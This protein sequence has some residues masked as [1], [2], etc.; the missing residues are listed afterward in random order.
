M[1]WYGVYTHALSQ[2]PDLHWI[3]FTS[4]GQMVSVNNN[5]KNNKNKNNSY[6]VHYKNWNWGPQPHPTDVFITLSG[7]YSQILVK[8]RQANPL[9]NILIF[10]IYGLVIW[11][12]LLLRLPWYPANLHLLILIQQPILYYTYIS[13]SGNSSLKLV[14]DVSGKQIYHEWETLHVKIHW[15]KYFHDDNV[16]FNQT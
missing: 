16:T 8:R 12:H 14:T 1:R 13:N 7:L 5:N 15:A 4:S 3:V 10:G 9:A 11:I 2:V 6:L